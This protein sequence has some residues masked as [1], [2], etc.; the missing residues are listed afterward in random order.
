MTGAGDPIASLQVLGPVAL[1]RGAGVSSIP[2]LT[3]PR[4]LAVLAYLVLAR[5]RRLHSR[6]TLLALLWPETEQARGRHALRNALH[7]IRKALGEQALLT[8]GDALVGVAWEYLQCDALQMEEA[9]ECRDWERALALYQ[10]ELLTGFHAADAPE[11]EDWLSA[12]RTWFRELA[13]KSAGALAEERQQGG[14]LA[15]AIRAAERRVQLSPSEEG[16]CRQLMLLLAQHGEAAAARR[17]YD[18]LEQR[19]RS[20]FGSTP[21]RETRALLETIEAAPP[22]PLRAEQGAR[23]SR[24]PFGDG[25]GTG[26][27]VPPPTSE[28]S[29][30]RV[31]WPL[32][33]GAMALMLAAGALLARRAVPLGVATPATLFVV[34]MVNATGDSSATWLSEGLTISLRDQFGRA[35]WRL[36][37]ESRVARALQSTSSPDAAA[38]AAGA[39]LLLSG[40]ADSV[41]GRVRLRLTALIPGQARPAAEA[42][43]LV[44]SNRLLDAELQLV[45][46]VIE[47]LHPDL[48]ADSLVAALRRGTSDEAAYRYFLEGWYLWDRRYSTEDMRQAAARFDSALAR[49]PVYPDALAGRARVRFAAAWS[50]DDLAGARMAAARAD[51]RRALELDSTSRVALSV[52]GAVETF[53]DSAAGRRLLERAVALDPDRADT[54]FLLGLHYGF[55]GEYVIAERAFQ[56]AIDL[57]PLAP[58]FYSRLVAVRICQGAFAR[59]LEGVAL[60]RGVTSRPELQRD[61]DYRE[62]S[63]LLALGRWREAIPLLEQVMRPAPELVEALGRVR[64]SDDLD[65]VL[66]RAASRPDAAEAV[67]FLA[68]LRPGPVQAVLAVQRGRPDMAI[69]LLLEARAAGDVSLP[70]ACEDPRLQ[71]LMTDR[72]VAD[73]MR[74]TQHP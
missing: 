57:E 54:F 45:R 47:R 33:V 4:P 50:G 27:L 28:A 70:M 12:E 68:G 51:A 63:L 13:V 71:Q 48:A 43:V 11:F 8:G 10:G 56:R 46:R 40:R 41:A 69:R 21:S 32:V 17:V 26:R 65:A 62:A 29:R 36:V 44:E 52:L 72:R 20:E 30:R 15:G 38:R 16:G 35:G 14:D 39:A 9:V 37:P 25:T 23:A 61:I 22:L 64:S 6:D 2:E 7:L 34:P 49:D 58:F 18:A 3:Q 59:A 24:E 60:W 31:R 55:R 67:A 42:E 66:L 74:L 53:R 5:P 19:V 73:A 1:H